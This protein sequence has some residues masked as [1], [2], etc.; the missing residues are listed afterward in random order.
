MK[1]CGRCKVEKNV[2][3]FTVKDKI[4]GRLQSFCKQCKKTYNKSHYAQNTE[5]YKQHKSRKRVEYLVEFYA[6]LKTLSC[7]DCSVTDF[8]VLEFDHLKDKSFNISERVAY[9]PL[10]T[11]MTEINKCEVVCANCHRVRTAE[12]GGQYKYLMRG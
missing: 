11:L 8:R 3:E 7:M 9:T 2:S 1:L 12:R 4:T 5:T 6:Y 10:K